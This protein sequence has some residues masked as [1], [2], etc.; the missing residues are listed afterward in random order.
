MKSPRIAIIVCMGAALGCSKLGPPGPASDKGSSASP[1]GP[2]ASAQGQGASAPGQ[3]AS[4]SAAGAGASAQGPSGAQPGKAAE[5]QNPLQALEQ[6][7]QAANALGGKAGPA[8]AVNWREL[9][10][11]L[12][13]DV[14]GWKADGEGKGETSAMG[15]LQVT[16][17]RRRY[18]KAEV[19][20]H[21]EIVDTSLSPALA[22]GYKLARSV[23]K[24]SSDEYVRSIDVSGQPGVEEW[25]AG[26]KHGEV[27]VL[28]GDRFLLK[29]EASG[30]PDTK[31]LVALVSKLD[32]GKLASVGK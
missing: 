1:S 22:A 29:A 4:G 3:G 9:L 26:A 7:Q 25:R 20:A 17:V 16:S 19:S 15:S 6:M 21:V 14:G 30:V 18:K 23:S 10:P 12:V 5:P 24:D 31:D 27:S 11:L 28:V 2:G 13:D 8:K 32:L